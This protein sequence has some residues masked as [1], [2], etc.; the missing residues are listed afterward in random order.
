MDDHL[1]NKAQEAVD[2]MK[3]KPRM[4]PCKALNLP[5]TIGHTSTIH[6]STTTTPILPT[7]PLTNS[8]APNDPNRWTG[9]LYTP[10]APQPPQGYPQHAQRVY[11]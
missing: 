11:R 3:M 4:N 6:A 10:E 2:N 7:P 1:E 9:E 8:H 5:Q